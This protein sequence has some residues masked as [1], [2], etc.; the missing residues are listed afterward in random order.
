MRIHIQ[1]P[2]ADDLFSITPA[3]WDAACARAGET[4][5]HASFGATGAEF[6]AAIGSAEVLIAQPGTVRRFLPFVAPHL[7][8]LF[9]TAAGLDAIMPFTWLPPRLVLVNNRG[10]HGAKMTN[11]AAMALLM[12]NARVPAYADAQRRQRWAPHFVPPIS[13][14]HVTV[15]GTGDVGSAVA[16]AARLLGVSS[17][18]VRTRAEPH[19]DFHRVV[20]VAELDA[21]LPESDFL[22]LA[23]P[24]LPATR[25]LLNRDRLALLAHGAAVV[26]VGRGALLDQEALADLLEAGE[27]SGAVLDVFDVEP[28][29]PGHRLWTTPNLF[30]TPHVSTDDPTSYNPASLDIF[31]VNLQAWR[32]GRAMPNRVDPRRGY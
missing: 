12:L 20:A 10:V 30:I 19:P 26:N 3:Q 28:L 4:G 32:E 24:L 2:S 9:C 23:C 11:Y 27:L 14:R 8:L 5:H 17:T 7:H 21:V 15:V 16:R 29:P 1:N 25:N 13:G 6:A 31:L 18:G 22:V